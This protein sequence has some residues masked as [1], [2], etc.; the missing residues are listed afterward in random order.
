MVNGNM[1]RKFGKI[2]DVWFLRNMSGQTEKQICSLFI[3]E[4]LYSPSN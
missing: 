2:L 1:H 3:I 4:V